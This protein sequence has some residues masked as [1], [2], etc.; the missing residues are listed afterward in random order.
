MPSSNTYFLCSSQIM[1]LFDLSIRRNLVVSGIVS[2]CRLSTVDDGYWFT[3]YIGN[4]NHLEGRG[5]FDATWSLPAIVLVRQDNV[6]QK[7]HFQ[8]LQSTFDQQMNKNFI[9]CRTKRFKSLSYPW[10]FLKI[11]IVI[12][13]LCLPIVCMNFQVCKDHL[14][15]HAKIY[16][17]S[18]KLN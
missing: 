11:R 3:I 6:L 15:S 16:F 12:A 13:N 5:L 9:Q 14:F 4:E 10:S 1:F 2:N 8:A 18:K 7:S 17:I